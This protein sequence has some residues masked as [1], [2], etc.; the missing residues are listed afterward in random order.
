MNRHLLS[1]GDLT[2]ARIIALQL[3]ALNDRRKLL[4]DLHIRVK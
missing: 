2:R 3:E 4:D 1:T